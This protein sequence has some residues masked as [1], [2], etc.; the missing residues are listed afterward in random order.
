MMRR[1]RVLHLLSSTGYHGAENMAVELIRQL[2]KLGVENHIGA[3]RNHAASNLVAVA[4]ARPSLAG[5][6]I[7]ECQGRVDVR[8][9]LALR[10]YIAHHRIDIVH[11][12]KY[13]TNLYALLARPGLSCRLVGTC[14]NWLSETRALRFYAWL[15][16]RVLRGFDAAVGVSD[17]V[18]AELHRHLEKPKVS[19][20][21]NGV[22]TARYR[23]TADRNSAKRALGFAP[24]RKLVGFVGRLT[25]DK[26]VSYLL[27]A[28]RRLAG[29]GQ[30]IDL[31]IVGDGEYSETLKSEAASLGLAGNVTFAGQRD[32]TPAIYS[33]LDA[34]VL[35]SRQEAFP[36]V[37]IE[38]MACGAPVIATCV[39][40]VPQILE[41]GRLGL[42]VPPEDA[43][44][45]ADT[46]EWALTAEAEIETMA[47]R[48]R[49]QAGSAY[50]SA[51]MAARYQAVYRRVLGDDVLPDTATAT[52]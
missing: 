15:D 49:T 50:S 28:T 14:H 8:A 51:A 38:A 36:M 3:F 18:T 47:A 26:G 27:Q 44:S 43:A 46:L 45:L 32:D 25:R 35:P 19:K 31:L 30:A 52:G 13:K 23:R 17:D 34:F 21:G 39:G 1:M 24:N 10:R 37:V 29:R 16:K 9:V 2:A 6:Q 48:A 11:S 41:H 5:S 7:F 4:T 40:D 20:I 12:H 42:L 22:D 33:A